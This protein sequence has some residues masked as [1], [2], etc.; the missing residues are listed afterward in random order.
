MKGGARVLAMQSVCPARAF[1]EF[2]LGGAPLEPP[3]RPLDNRMRGTL[4]H[5]LLEGLYRL[6]ACAH[7]LG[8]L[9]PAGLRPLF[10]QEIEA[11]LSEVL[12]AR[13]PYMDGLRRIEKERLWSLV[14]TLRELEVERPGFSVVTELC[15]DVTIGPLSLRVRLDRLDKLDAGGELVID[16]KTGR[17]DP[18]GWKRP[19]VPDSQ[20]PLYAVSGRSDG[21][22]VVQ[23]RAPGARLRGV[24][25]DVI[26]L[27]GMSTPPKFFRME[28]LDWPGVLDRWQSRL[29]M[30]ATEFAAGDFRVNP[31]DRRWAVDQFAGLTRIHEFLPEI[32]SDGLPGEDGGE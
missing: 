17:V 9:E 8:Q 3:S 6:E 29:E 28:G 7:G 4:V 19:R 21:I 24:G 14:L 2:R 22:A 10:E 5:V 11:V 23:L 18:G 1:I 27:P 12:G 13:D 20:L 32:E 26:A 30:L 31:A 16:Y 15:R 25:A